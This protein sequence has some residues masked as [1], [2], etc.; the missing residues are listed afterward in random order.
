MTITHD[1]IDR[2]NAMV[3]GLETLPGFQHVHYIDLRN[4]LPTGPQ[5][6]VWWANELHPTER[7]F[8]AVADKFDAALRILP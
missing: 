1:L 5:Y 2:F 6:K 8:H 4:T 7:G 3:Q